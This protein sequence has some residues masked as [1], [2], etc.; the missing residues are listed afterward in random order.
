[1]LDI[2]KDLRGLIMKDAARLGKPDRPAVPVEQLD[3]QFMFEFTDLTT[4]GGLS[5]T[6]AFGG[7]REIAFFDDGFEIPEMSEFHHT[8]EV[9]CET[10]IVFPLDRFKA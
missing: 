5:N 4:Q 9:S 7:S 3:T 2:G 10:E 6:Q 8:S 1:M